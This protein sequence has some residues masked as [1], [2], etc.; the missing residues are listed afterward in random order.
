MTHPMHEGQRAAVDPS[1]NQALQVP[2]SPSL[3]LASK[4]RL[5][6]AIAAL[7][8]AYF[9]AGRFGLSLAIVHPSA[10][11]VWPP[12]GIAFAALLIWG[13]R[14]WPGVLLG[15]FLVNLTASGGVGASLMIAGGN[16]LEALAGAWLIQHYANGAKVFERARN[17]FKFVLLAALL[18]TLVSPTI[19]VATLTLVGGLGFD[20]LGTVWLTWWLGDM[21]GE[22]V[23]A[24]LLVIWLTQPLP[25]L[26]PP[27]IA[28][29]VALLLAVILTASFV[30]VLQRRAELEFLAF[31]PLLWAAVRFGQRGAVTAASLIFMLALA[32]TLQGLGPFALGDPRESLLFLQGFTATIATVA[33]ILAAVVGERTRAERRLEI[34]EALS[35]ILADSPGLDDAGCEVLQVLCERGDWNTGAIWQV[36]R[37]ENELV[38]ID[39]WNIRGAATPLFEEETRRRRFAPGIGLPGR[40]LSSGSPA[41]IP[42]LLKDANF[43]RGPVAA[44]EGLRAAFAFP[45]KAAGEVVGVVECFSREVRELDDDFLRVTEDIGSQLGRFIERKNSEKALLQSEKE[46]A[47]FFKTSPLSLH[48][49]D[50]DGVILKANE[51][52]LAMLGYAEED[53][54]G[55]NIV[56][57]HEDRGAIREVLARLARGESVAEL[58]ARLRRK[59]GS[60]CDVLINS[61]GYWNQGR[62]VHI[63]SFTRDVTS[64][65]VADE[66][67]A[68]LAAIIESS[69]DAIVSKT[70]D[71]VITSWNR[72]A[73][74]LFGY[75][76]EEMVGRSILTIIPQELRAEEATILSRLRRGESIEHFETVRL[77]RDGRRVDIS[78]SL[79]PIRNSGGVI[80]GASKIARDITDRKK[81][82][83]LLAKAKEDLLQANERLE[84]RVRERTTELELANAALLQNLAEQKRLE[85]QLQQAQKMES[86]GTLAGGIAHDF[87]NTLN[88][89]KAYATLISARYSADRQIVDSVRI[90]DDEIN[91]S[92]A[93][94]R[95][96]LTLAR[97]TETVLRPTNVN[98]VIITVRELIRG[99]FPK[100][101]DVRLELDE[102]L[103]SVRAD[104]NL[105]NQALLNI[106]VNAR[107]A[108]PGGGTLT[109][110]TKLLDGDAI[111]KAA[112]VGAGDAQV[113]ITISD[114]GTG[115]DES[116]RSRI[117]EPFYTTKAVGDGT[118]LGLAMVYGI[119]RNHNGS[120]EVQSEVGRGTAFHILLPAAQEQEEAV[121]GDARDLPGRVQNSRDHKATVFVVEDESAMVLLLERA[122]SKA[123]YRS[124]VAS[125]GLEAVDLYRRHKREVDVVLMDLGLPKASGSEVIRL[126]KQEN[127]A[128][129]IIVTTGYLEPELKAELFEAGVQDYINK[130]YSL[131]AVLRT[132]EA[133]LSRSEAAPAGPQAESPSH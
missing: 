102:N 42:D 50:Q 117:F 77:A 84:A 80:I 119:V 3:R 121:G 112:A 47:D 33:L 40:V 36:E 123:N 78:L 94:V 100:T 82:E 30:F 107:D 88:I 27:R 53:Y 43:P 110:G 126:I 92:A 28:E 124:L 132:V 58:P 81:S 70:L 95:Q 59:D 118:G 106:C 115:M 86:I 75:M 63:R 116:V 122:L 6:A 35:R 37:S 14:L 105:L 69:V 96:L 114:T 44:R 91:R 25:K 113:C 98:E 13:C 65:K 41:W 20:Q 12:T 97:K 60:M 9:L 55:R 56:E 1:W 90:I 17:I 2:E 16:T 111:P 34:Q 89:I 49:L 51:A 133:V 99:I 61:S 7:A 93:V 11:A 125:D 38:C 19:G 62:F 5:A 72:G 85:E 23:I 103:P 52:E 48:W 4:A 68:R 22:L 24:P 31:L 108:M 26:N 73:E 104:A 130:P 66:T 128:A 8:A 57:F 131:D 67:R 71:G 129:K 74:Q 10:S 76:A 18:S 101:I 64:L 120:I 79:S 87:N 54:I 29:A 21:T 46:L 39:L 109:L 83:A 32:G 15:A 127:P 45:I